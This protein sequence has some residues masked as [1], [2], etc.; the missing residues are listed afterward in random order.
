MYCSR[1]RTAWI[2]AFVA[3][4]MVFILPACWSGLLAQARAQGLP[5]PSAAN[6][7]EEREEHA[8][9]EQL[10]AHG[11]RRLAPDD[12]DPVFRAVVARV[13]LPPPR[14]LASLIDLSKPAVLFVRRLL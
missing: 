12:P 1:T 11:V 5:P 6:N 9:P 2:S 13:E 8:P 7:N 14:K 3:L 10:Q 4:F